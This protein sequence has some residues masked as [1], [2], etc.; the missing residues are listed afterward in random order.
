MKSGFRAIPPKTCS[1][2]ILMI[3]QPTPRMEL[4]SRGILSKPGC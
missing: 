2:R 4:F 3:S 1:R